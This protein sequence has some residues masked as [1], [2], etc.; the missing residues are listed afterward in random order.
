MQTVGVY[1]AISHT[2]FNSLF[3]ATNGMSGT[4]IITPILKFKNQDIRVLGFKSFRNM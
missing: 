2:L 4:V 3:P 1:Q